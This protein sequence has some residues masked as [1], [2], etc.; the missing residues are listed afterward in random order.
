MEVTTTCYIEKDDKYL[1]LHRIKKENDIN[2]GKWIGVGGHVE[3]GES[4]TEAII[5]EVKEET[6]LILNSCK[7]RGVLTFVQ[8]K[9]FTEYIFLYTSDDYSGELIEECDEGVLG[10]IDKDKVLEL[11]HFQ[12][13]ELR[14]KKIIKDVN[15]NIKKGEIVGL[16]GLMG[17]GRT[18]F[19]MSVFGK[20]YGRHIS[21]SVIKN[22][23]EI[24]INN[25]LELKSKLEELLEET[26]E[27]HGLQKK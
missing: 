26:K 17:A 7:L 8:N 1:M 19:A 4:P 21:G 6:G 27:Y 14:Y 9:T 2:E 25:D 23:K 13:Y 16:S 15:I 11:L 24:K 5:R 20:A 18:E 22:G 3:E 10:W 12:K